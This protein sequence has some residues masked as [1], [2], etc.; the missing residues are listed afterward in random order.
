MRVHH[1][2]LLWLVAATNGKVKAKYRRGAILVDMAEAEDVGQKECTDAREGLIKTQC[3]AE[4]SQVHSVSECGLA[5][6]L[7][8]ESDVEYGSD[9]R[10]TQE[11]PRLDESSSSAE[12]WWVKGEVSC[13]RQ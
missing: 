12:R 6:F 3:G 13:L 9:A 1:F 10:R 11:R 7:S 2:V 5:G 4:L 8:V